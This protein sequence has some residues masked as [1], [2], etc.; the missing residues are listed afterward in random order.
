MN[1]LYIL[2]G[3]ALLILGRKYA[4]IFTA[5]IVYFVTLE[6]ITN[7]LSDFPYVLVIFIGLVFAASSAL[8]ASLTKPLAITL[9][10]ILAASYLFSLLATTY[11]WFPGQT[12]APYLAGGLLGLVMIAAVADWTMLVFSSLV[13]AFMVTI[14]LSV[15]PAWRLVYFLG[16]TL[17]GIIVQLLILSIEKPAF[18]P[19][20]AEII[21]EKIEPDLMDH[22][23]NK[24]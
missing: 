3:T 8:L 24:G 16:I 14:G 4:W 11:K 7:A 17:I 6:V 19:V 5:G 10:G 20:E 23:K 22:S 18:V 15:D 1:I 12:W 13:G 2:I 21:E 9:A